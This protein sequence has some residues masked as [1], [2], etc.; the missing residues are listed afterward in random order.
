MVTHAAYSI[1]VTSV[2]Q[3]DFELLQYN[4][5]KTYKQGVVGQVYGYRSVGKEMGEA[6]LFHSLVKCL[7]QLINHFLDLYFVWLVVKFFVIL[8][9]TM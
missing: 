1:R 7:P 9:F 5:R 2:G 8:S 3:D 6:V 4:L